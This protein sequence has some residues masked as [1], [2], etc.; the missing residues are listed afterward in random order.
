MEVNWNQLTADVTFYVFAGITVIAA[1]GVISVRNPVHSVMLLVLTFFSAAGL[2]VLIEA[3]F[4]AAILVIVYMGAVAILFLF[5]VM[6]L[7]VDYDALRQGFANH[8]PMGIAVGVVV[9]AE[10]GAL[11]MTYHVGSSIP[12]T[13]AGADHN[14]MAI[15]KVLYTQYLYPFEL[16]SLVLLVALIGA[17]ALTHR[18]RQ[19]VL[20]QNITEQNLR[21][22]ED[23]VAIKQVAPGEGAKPQ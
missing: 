18:K 23:S 10:L 12:Q 8:L 2:F 6:M 11:A 9:L 20:R 1:L 22:R 19:G 7:D 13:P 16:A 3:E 14:I 15:G 21:R 4:L 5:V 17:I